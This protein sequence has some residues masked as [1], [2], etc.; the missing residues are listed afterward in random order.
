MK[1][2]PFSRVQINDWEHDY[3]TNFA[4]AVSRIT[5]WLLHVDYWVNTTNP[6]DDIKESEMIQL[7]VYVV[8]NM[9][10][11]F[12]VRGVKNL[13][14]FCKNIITPLATKNATN[15][16]GGIKTRYYIESRLSELPLRVMPNESKILKAINAIQA[17]HTFLSN[18]PIRQ[19]NEIPAHIAAKFSFGWCVPYAEALHSITQLPIKALIAVKNTPQNGSPLGYIHSFVLHPDGTIE[20]SWGKQPIEHLSKRFNLVEYEISES[21]HTKVAENVKKHSEIYAKAYL[22][23]EEVLKKYRS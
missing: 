10:N 7:R 18:L 4:I 15:S 6:R 19:K 22:E 8:D 11:V 12:D 16:I 2:V 17:N 20:D 23:A 9:N 14:D 3:C 1:S 13:Q 5:G 21:E